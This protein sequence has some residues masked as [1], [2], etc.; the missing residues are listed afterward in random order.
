VSDLL[1]TSRVAELFGSSRQHVVDMCNRGELAFVW[2]GRHR[3]ISRVEVDRVV[4][5]R[6]TRDQER[7]LWLHHAVAGR[8]V[9][10]PVATLAKARTNIDKLAR[11]HGGTLAGE[12][13]DR[14]R[15]LLDD[16][17]DALLEA[18]TS[19]A[20]HALELRQNSPFAGVLPNEERLACL[21]AFRDHWS[22][23]HAA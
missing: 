14:W 7:S 9:T 19:T 2:V 20:P 8:L 12:Y 17:P 13:V 3:R 5:P 16:G 15:R 23:G 18:L 22:D 10:D 11:Q 6:L 21:K 4:R 1:T